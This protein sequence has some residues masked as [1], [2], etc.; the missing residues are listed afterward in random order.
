[1]PDMPQTVAKGSIL[2][3]LDGVL[4]D[5]AARARILSELQ[6]GTPLLTIVTA[7]KVVLTD[8]ERTHLA[9]DWFGSAWWPDA[10]AGVGAIE[11]ILRAGFIDAINMANQLGVVIDTYWICH[12]GHGDGP[13][14]LI[15][16]PDSDQHVE[17]TVLWS[18]RQVTVFMHTPEPKQPSIPDAPRTIDEPIR[19]WFW[20]NGKVEQ[21][22]PKHRP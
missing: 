14:H 2:K 18:D 6:A 8:D 3:R 7:E 12:P 5:E 17:V 4:R 16:T 22:R 15:Q 20:K 9:N 21:D 10:Q 19:V 1:M 11:K 13:G